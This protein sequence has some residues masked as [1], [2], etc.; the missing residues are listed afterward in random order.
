MNIAAA[1]TQSEPRNRRVGYLLRM[2]PRFSQTFIVNEILELERQG[3]EI[4]IA[5]L[6]LPTDGVFHE[7]ISRVRAKVDYLAEPGESSPGLA[8]ASLRR[9]RTPSLRR[10]RT[11]SPRPVRNGQLALTAADYAR[12]IRERIGRR[13]LPWQELVQAGLLVQ[14][15]RK[16]RI[17]H[18][19]VHFGTSEATVAWLASGLGGPGY[20]LT[21]HA[22]DIFR[23]NVDRRL[24]AEKING[25]RFTVTVCRSNREYLVKLPGVDPD[26]VRVNYNGID[27]DFFSCHTGP[28]DP[29]FVFSVGRL[30]EKKGFD[31]L[32]HAI[33]LLRD[34]GLPLR[35]EI[36]GEGCEKPRLRERIERLGLREQVKLVG[37]LKQDEVRQ[38]L[39]QAGC[40]ALPCL[41]AADG[42]VDA[43]P[44][45]LLEALACGCP[46]V[47][48]RISGVPE[49]IESG[50]SGLL[51]EPGDDQALA[52]AIRRLVLDQQLA[53]ALA[54]GGRRRAEERFDLRRN[55][56]VMAD[57]LLG[58][59]TGYQ[60]GTACQCGTGDQPVQRGTGYRGGT[61]YQPVDSL[62]AAPTNQPLYQ[63][64]AS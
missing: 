36:A 50:V 3:L 33:G 47:S 30:I 14:W 64:E 10:L 37:P 12:A 16:R 42:N 40:F 38:R 62:T 58:C 52:A 15:A 19:H 20:S 24:L 17:E 51:V 11:A 53:H 22:F 27:L 39:Q 31:R 21:L 48:T 60:P 29:R 28:R 34:Q 63:P 61:G 45:V 5:S 56:G 44:T 32:I 54:E 9:L 49:I 35:C 57:W 4:S 41:Q 6:R 26:R 13:D 59:G 1:G 43:L 23:D 7:S 8:A 55:G 46:A 2:Y 25:S 18:L